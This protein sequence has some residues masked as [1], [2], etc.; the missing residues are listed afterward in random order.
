MQVEDLSFDEGQ[1]EAVQGPERVRA[2][3]ADRDRRLAPGHSAVGSTIPMDDEGNVYAPSFRPSSQDLAS[4]VTVTETVEPGD[5]LVIDTDRRGLMRRGSSAADNGVV[6]IVA[7][8]PGLVLGSEVE[9]GES[10]TAKERE[11][12]ADFQ[13]KVPVAFSGV[14]DCKVDA[15]YGAVWTGNLLVTSPTPG[16]A[17]AQQGPLPGTVLGKALEP[18]QEGVGTIKVL[19]MLR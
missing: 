19:V 15:S 10:E 4:L 14:V 7:A 5:V 1:N 8:A 12:S 17:M 9:I 11:Q 3:R 6:G 16:H 2:A 13:L 18:L